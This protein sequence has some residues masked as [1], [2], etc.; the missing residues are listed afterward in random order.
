MPWPRSAKKHSVDIVRFSHPFG[1]G[2]I[3]RTINDQK[4]ASAAF[5]AARADQEKIVQ[6]QPD[7]AP[8]LCVLGLVD[9]VLG[10]KDDALREG[11]RA[12]EL[13]PV[14]RDALMGSP[15][16][17]YFAMIAAWTGEKDLT[18]EQLAEVT[19]NSRE[20]TYG[21]LKLLPFWDWLRGDPCF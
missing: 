9:A 13:L 12:L 21:Q 16:S 4:K 6:A 1:E 10:R 19:K 11:W 15:I 3:A 14:E 2:L 20:A 5:A 7:Y 18:C 17:L 8:A